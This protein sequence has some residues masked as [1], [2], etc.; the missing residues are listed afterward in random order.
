[1]N[2]SWREEVLDNLCEDI[3]VG[4]V[5]SMV[6]E[7]VSSGIPFF[8]SKNISEYEIDWTDIKY[9][10][11]DFHNKLKKSALAP[12]DVA[13]VRTGKPG[14]ACVIPDT[15]QVAN[16]SDLVIVRTNKSVLNPNYLAYFLNSTARSQ[17]NAHLVGAVQQHFNVASAKKIKVPV[18]SIEEQQRIANI[19]GTLDDKIA[20]NRQINQTL[21]A[22]AQALF[23]SWF[24]DFEPVRAKLAALETGEDPTRAAMRAISGK[25]NAELDTLQT[26]DP[27]AYAQLETTASLFPDA[28]EESELGMVPEGWEVRPFGNYLSSTI[29]GDWGKDESD[30]KHT[31]QALILRGTDLPDV[32]AGIDNNIPK[33]WVEP[34]K[35]KGRQLE[36]GDIVIEVSGGSKNQPTGRS[37]LITNTLLERLG[38]IVEPASFCRRFTPQSFERGIFLALLLS[39]IYAEGKTWQYQN[40]STGISNFQTISFLEREFVIMPS[41]DILTAL[42]HKVLPIFDKIYSNE[43]SNLAA[44]RDT[45]LPKL[46]SG[47]IQLNV[48]ND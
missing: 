27:D 24:V 3:T 4:Y 30:E 42:S 45:L 19:L 13:I 17:V 33:R 16:C 7:Y 32:Y 1:M 47:E 11:F 9:I 39:K 21:E 48:V 31:V 29:G 18:P 2:S 5:G 25:T 38:S 26:T 37:L 40:Q 41:I 6:E 15:V 14:T 35:L 8:R 43:N 34:K 36:A 10:S 46:L 23:K 28:L 44:L 22:M 12:G 20:L